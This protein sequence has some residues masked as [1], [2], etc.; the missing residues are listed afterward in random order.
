MRTLAV[1]SQRIPASVSTA[2]RAS[3]SVV[4]VSS[5]SLK[6][7]QNAAVALSGAS[8]DVVAQLIFVSRNTDPGFVAA[9]ERNGGEFIAAP[10]GSSRAEM[11]DLGMRQARGTIVAVRDDVAVGDAQ[12]MNAYRRV[13]PSREVARP[14]QA[15][16]VVMDT[17]VASR[18]PL[19]D[20]PG[21]RQSAEVR[22]RNDAGELAAAV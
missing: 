14:V 9:V 15:E 1:G 6:D 17:L 18:A 2:T 22:P 7:G 10:A 19:A 13:I 5:G 16:S 20:L 12:W 11:C 21:S 4:V 3:L 8:R